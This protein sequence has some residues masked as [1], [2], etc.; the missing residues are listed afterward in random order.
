[1]A[2]QSVIQR[3]KKIPYTWNNVFIYDIRDNKY[4]DVFIDF[5]YYTLTRDI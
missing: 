1:M 5:G 3:N 4:R 2:L